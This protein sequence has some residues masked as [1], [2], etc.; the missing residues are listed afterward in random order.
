MKNRLTLL[1]LVVSVISTPVCAESLIRKVVAGVAVQVISEVI[2]NKIE[3][4]SRQNSTYAPPPART[5]PEVYSG[6][7]SDRERVKNIIKVILDQNRPFYEIARYYA[8]NVDY[9]DQGVI[10]NGAIV[11]ENNKFAQRWP[12]RRYDIKS[13]DEIEISNNRTFAVA[14][15]TLN[16][17]VGNAKITK[18]GQ[19][20]AYVL[21]GDFNSQP[22]IYAIKGWVQ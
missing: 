3:S 15:Y 22:H 20:K 6:S 1:A 11:Q 12:Y 2:K 10:S 9:F 13:F 16:F 7:S 8:N 21:I 5:D 4:N 19:T 17:E 18:R 14:R